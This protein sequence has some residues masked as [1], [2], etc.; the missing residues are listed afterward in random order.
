MIKKTLLIKLLLLLSSS[1][2]QELPQLVFQQSINQ[3]E[4][5][6]S[7]PEG[8]TYLVR[9]GEQFI[10]IDQ[11]SKLQLGAIK[12]LRD[13]AGSPS[14]GKVI[15]LTNTD[16]LLLQPR[17]ILKVNILAGIIDTFFNA[18]SFPEFI[19]NMTLNGT[20]DLLIASKIYP[21]NKNET[22]SFS[23]VQKQ[24]NEEGE[25]EEVVVYD[26][27]QNC[28]LHLVSLDNKKVLLSK[29]ISENITALYADK[30]SLLA[31]SFNRHLIELNQNLEVMHKH[32]LSESIHT[33]IHSIMNLGESY[34]ILSHIAPKFLHS[35]A[36]GNMVF[37]KKNTGIIKNLVFEKQVWVKKEDDWSSFD[38]SPS[39]NI[40][41][42]QFD[43]TQ[44]MLWV[45]YGYSALARVDPKGFSIKNF[46]SEYES[47]TFF[48]FNR[49]KTHFI[50]VVDEKV[51]FFG[52]RGEIKLFSI[53]SQRFQNFYKQPDTRVSYKN[54]YKFFDNEGNY[55]M[56]CEKN[57]GVIEI[58]PSNSTQCKTLRIECSYWISPADTSILLYGYHQLYYGKLHLNR[59]N[60]LEDTLRFESR[61]AGKTEKITQHPFFTALPVSFKINE[62]DKT[63]K[64]L[65]QKKLPVIISRAF[66]TQ[67][68]ALII[69]CV[70]RSKK[71]K[72][73][74]WITCIDS[75]GNVAY[76]TPKQELG[77][78]I[79]PSPSKKFFAFFVTKKG[80]TRLNVLESHSG[81]KV[82][83]QKMNNDAFFQYCSFDKKEEVLFYT[84]RV[85]VNP[86][87]DFA[88][89][90]VALNSQKV[91]STPVAPKIPQFFSFSVDMEKNRIVTEN[92]DY[93]RIYSLDR[94]EQLFE[95][96]PSLSYMKVRP[97]E[98][99]FAV[100]T[101]N[102]YFFYHT[103][104]QNQVLFSVLTDQ[105]P[106]EI[107]NQ[108]YFSGGK[109]VLKNL[110]FKHQSKAFASSDFEAYFNLPGKVVTAA[111]SSN[112]QFVNLLKSVEEKRANR[113]SLPPIEALLKSEITLQ[114]QGLDQI[115]D[116]TQEDFLTLHLKIHS[117]N[118][119]Q[120]IHILCNEVPV[121]GKQGLLIAANTLQLDTTLIIPL[122]MGVNNLEVFATN[123]PGMSSPKEYL[124]VYNNT[125]HE[126]K[127]H[128]IG[129][130]V[131]HY[132]QP[133]HDLSYAVKDI[134]D[135]VAALSNK[136][137]NHVIVDTLFNQQ[138]TQE[139]ILAL[140]QKLMTLGVNDKVI[141]S[142]SGHGLLS[143]DLDYYLATYPVNFMNPQ[144]G[145]LPYEDL[146]WLLDSIPPRQKLLLLDACH[147]GEVDKDELIAVNEAPM[148]E[149]VKGAMVLG[150]KKPHLGLK[151][152]FELMQELFANVNRGTGATIISAAG[153]DQFAYEKSHFAN[154][155][156]TYSILEL[157]QQQNEITVSEL[158]N[159]VGMRVLELT[160]GQQ[161]PTSRSE[162]L[163]F[164][165][166]VW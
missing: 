134:R 91:S 39:N 94:F 95:H 146:E 76:S 127:L 82:F 43:E 22:V 64:K 62:N 10:L 153:G 110:A 122:V 12:M 145:G 112:T 115:E 13:N 150:Y 126:P 66:K 40:K 139:N 96:K 129:I 41:Q 69:R 84:D 119:I 79:I 144:Q 54:M 114:I 98:K 154:G 6:Y 128:F 130:G 9:D 63:L 136:Y 133:G 143:K 11:V 36:S 51:R 16:F 7:S 5:V 81:K 131:D 97:E 32:N 135:L 53:G 45:N 106:I 42:I 34:L 142:F 80:K 35:Y 164:D 102:E 118:P 65:T 75:S 25:V 160:N 21:I 27:S 46:E 86:D 15:M 58:F 83:S 67:D 117:Q 156:F 72:L 92:Y 19:V 20:S 149:G 30:N 151:N 59:F 17:E 38:F 162:T 104:T 61:W 78:D 157:M 107:L 48:G 52:T 141:I 125:V 74:A 3:I 124:S 1:F 2:A 90:Q 47:A 33:P 55:Y 50:S 24:K 105:K 108:T 70:D 155:V 163:E 77:I 101:S 44:K 18:V 161:R 111:G 103:S 166:K 57:K 120:G 29:P 121:Y 60:S 56:V 148:P 109:E 28:R 37:W 8:G 73:T 85:K 158:K 14:N 71:Q 138:V 93:F 116:Y 68:G 100:V 147:S 137:G 26:Q 49:S 88:L 123:E 89:F 23:T 159:H 152:S 165:W 4:Q 132:H 31:G 99:G 87:P 113:A 140:K